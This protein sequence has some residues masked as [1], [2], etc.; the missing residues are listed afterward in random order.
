MQIIGSVVPQ[1]YYHLSAVDETELQFAEDFDLVNNGWWQI[2]C[3]GNNRTEGG[4]CLRYITDNFIYDFGKLRTKWL[5]PTLQ[6]VSFGL[7]GNFV[8]KNL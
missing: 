2:L 8:L 6:T 7:K 1:L 5:Q 3:N 4:H